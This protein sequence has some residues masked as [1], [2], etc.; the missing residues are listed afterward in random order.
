MATHGLHISD[1]QTMSF[2]DTDS[3]RSTSLR[4]TI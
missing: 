3:S 4:I 1:E 2:G